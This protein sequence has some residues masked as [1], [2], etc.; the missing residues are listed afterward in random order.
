MVR[1]DVIDR[2]L[3]MTKS[4][5]VTIVTG[6]RKSGKTILCSESFPNRERLDLERTETRA[7]AENDPRAFLARISDGAILEGIQRCPDLVPCLK[8]AVEQVPAPGR[9]I[10]NGS[11]APP[12][13]G[14]AEPIILLPLTYNEEILFRKHPESLDDVMFT[15]SCPRI[16]AK[17]YPPGK[18]YGTYLSGYLERDVREI[19]NVSD[20]DTFQRFMETCA[21]M[22]A[23]PLNL[24]ALAGDCGVSQPTAKKWLSVLERTFLA[25]RLSSYQGGRRR[26][27]KMP[28]LHFYDTGLLCWL[29]GIR[30][31]G[32]LADHPL[33]EFVFTT[34]V[35]SEIVKN[36][37]HRGE[38][39]GVFHYRDRQGVEADAVVEH[40]DARS[41]V[42]AD[43]GAEVS[44]DDDAPGD[45]G[46]P[47]VVYGGDEDVI[48][49]G[50]TFVSWRNIHERTW[51]AS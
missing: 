47:L 10:L 27:M 17:H 49:S 9:W 51:T 13:E 44:K 34:W 41:V 39:G 48:Q 5:P 19:T 30:S 12:I 31:P 22:A 25:F 2:F 43:A 15:G 8:E 38:N 46:E 37:V 1:R 32:E 16:A 20:L 4:E 26:T 50:T 11:P 24:S 18:W 40:G 36:R 23:G 42:R 35:V 7:A 6:P 14:F 3:R 45:V 29:L 21:A 33:R 28:K